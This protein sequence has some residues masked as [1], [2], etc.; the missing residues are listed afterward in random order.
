[1]AED[2]NNREDEDLNSE[3]DGGQETYTAEEVEAIRKEMNSNSEKWV[4]KVISEKK[5]FET[6]LSEVS[7]V[8][9]DEKYLVELH[10]E[11]PD[12]AKIIL[13][14]YYAWQD[15][16]TYKESIS[17]EVDMQ[18]PKV[19]QRMV[20]SE[21]KKLAETN[22]IDSKKQDFI[23]KLK[24]TD[25]EVISFEEAFTERT[26]LKSFS[27]NKLVNH[28]EKAYRDVNDN[29][30][31]L[32]EFKLQESIANNIATW[33]WKNGKQVIG[34]KESNTVKNS[35]YNKNFLREQWIL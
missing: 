9:D 20:E 35:E 28:F 34:K 7:K 22:L 3:N 4:Q 23:K 26:Q 32:K 15:I 17:Y 30:E 19:I 13:D 2:E 18:D 11:N 31:A 25:E 16:E 8:A 12:V 29:T 21:A 24:M 33:S 27:I 14:Q 10:N 1:M 6:A 5:N